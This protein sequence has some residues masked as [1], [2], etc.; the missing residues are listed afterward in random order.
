MRCGGL[1]LPAI[2]AKICGRPFD[3]LFLDKKSAWVTKNSNLGAKV[4]AA[5]ETRKKALLCALR[6]K[7]IT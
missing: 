6:Q 4:E 1:L 3:V 2:L 5:S 7:D